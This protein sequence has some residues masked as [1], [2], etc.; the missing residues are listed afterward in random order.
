MRAA[1]AIVESLKAHGV[2]RV[3]CVPGESYLALLDAFCD[4]GI[5]VV[6]CRHEGG[7]GFMACAEAKLTGEPCVFLVSRGPGATNASIAVHM[8]EQ[9]AL[10]VLL[11][12]GQVSRHERTRGV[13]QEMDY[14]PFFG[15]MAKG[16][17]EITE[18][19]RVHDIMPRA[20]RLAMQGTQ[21]PVV[22]SLP[23]DML[24]DEVGTETQLVFPPARAFHDARD[25]SQIQDLIG[26]AERPIAVV[27]SRLRGKAGAEAL[28][29]FAQAQRISVATTWKNQDVFDN[30]SEL[31]AGH[32][33]FGTPQA[34][35]KLL[36]EADLIIA[37]GTRLGDVA[38]LGY[39]FPSAPAPEQTLVHV[40]PD[41]GPLNKNARADLAL[42]ADP[43]AVMAA[44]AG[45]ARVVSSA[46]EAW[47]SRLHGFM[48]DHG[49]FKSINP[50][51]GVDFGAVVVALAKHAPADCVI[52]TDAGNMSTWVHRH[53][54]MSPANTLLGGIAGAMGLGVPAA[55]A[56]SLAQPHRMAI[57]IV[58]DGGVLMTGQE[59]ATAVAHGAAP[60]IVIA[61]NG[62]YGTIRT[63]QE[64]EYPGRVSGTTLVNP[65]FKMWAESFGVAA[66]QLGLGDDVERVVSA[67]LSAKGAAVLHVKS[68]RQALSAFGT[69]PPAR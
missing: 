30:H 56:V 69:L 13:F 26:R 52:T 57:C 4:S 18:G 29:R 54:S 7:A 42:V 20:F 48:A 36:A 55:V 35:R 1:D 49:V 47:I 39:T 44:L 5:E 67:F 58:G 9:D 34:Q 63:H 60:K 21:G 50:Q 65:D 12:I 64:R 33:G 53:W 51:D 43:A 38:S 10:P 68:S 8:A 46:R 41:S 11:L 3:Y 27:G 25:I 2:R 32:L 14:T 15:S 37:A 23:E 66:F 62:I 61:D 59:L 31:Y 19:V 6:V 40:Y 22:L 24:R 28:A 45:Q 17:F 16:V